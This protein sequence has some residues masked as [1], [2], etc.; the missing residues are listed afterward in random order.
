VRLDGIY[1]DDI[2]L[3]KIFPIYTE[4][5]S[6]SAQQK[7][8]KILLKG[9]KLS[10][11]VIV[12]KDRR[13]DIYW[14]V[15]GFPEYEVYRKLKCTT[16]PSVVQPFTEK[17]E[18]RITLLKRMFF[19]Q[20]TKWLDK[21]NVISTLLDSNKSPKQIADELGTSKS[22]VE[23]YLIHPDIPPAI[24]ALA[25]ENRGSFPNLE[26]IR[27]LRLSEILTNRLYERAV[28]RIGDLERLTGEKIKMIKWLIDRDGFWE[29]KTLDKWD[30]LLLALDFK[31]TLKDTWDEEIQKR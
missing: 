10:S 27:K 25:R 4:D 11:H 15:A 2:P 22:Y 5:V 19:H 26:K 1:M 18:Q 21:H 3:E 24:V 28:K 23:A 6:N 13:D 8:M 9:K 16:I 31:K 7:M 17:T 30:M 29:L 12:E 20:P 14:L